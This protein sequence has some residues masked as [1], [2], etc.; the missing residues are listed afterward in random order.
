MKFKSIE[1]SAFRAYDKPEDASF[2]FTDSDG[3]ALNFV[4]LYAPNGFGKTSFYDAVEWG[5]T[6]EVSRLWRRDKSTEKSID[7]L[8]DINADKKR[9]DLLRNTNATGNTYV[10]YLTNKNSEPVKRDLAS[11]RTSKADTRSGLGTNLNFQ[12]VILSQEWISAFL[13]EDD[14][15]VRYKKFMKNPE[16]QMTDT[17]YQNLRVL[18]E[19]NDKRLKEL[20]G[21]IKTLESKITTTD[22]EDIL[23]AINELITRINSDYDSQNISLITL[24]TSQKEIKDLR[25]IITNTLIDNNDLDQL[26]ELLDS[27]DKARVGSEGLC[28]EK[29]YF[30]AIEN[31]E[32]KSK[33]QIEIEKNLKKFEKLNAL[34]NEREKL[35]SEKDKLLTEKKKLVNLINIFDKYQKIQNDINDKEQVKGT[36]KDQAST[37]RKNIENSNRE[38]LDAKNL[39]DS[40][41][42]RKTE[43]EK[44]SDSLPGLEADL[45]K[46]EEVIAT[47]ETS[48]SK[49]NEHILQGQERLAKIEEQIL[50][51]EQIKQEALQ[52]RY[53]LTSVSKDKIF[54]EIVKKL[55][56]NSDVSYELKKE[57]KLLDENIDQQEK[58]NQNIQE[59]ISEGLEIVNN[60]ETD[61]CPLCEYQYDSYKTLADRI[62]NNE[63]LSSALRILLQ[64]KNKLS[65]DVKT[66]NLAV[67]TLLEKL[68]AFYEEKLR[69]LKN[70]QEVEKAGIVENQ[71]IL[72]NFKKEL[73][74]ILK[75]QSDLLSKSNGRSINF[76]R[77]DLKESLRESIE[78]LEKANTRLKGAGKQL[79]NFEKNIKSIEGRIQLMISEIIKLEKDFDFITIKKWFEE[80]A[81][82][83]EIEKSLIEEELLKTGIILDKKLQSLQVLQQENDELAETLKSFNKITL[84]EK[85]GILKEE[86]QDL[87]KTIAAFDYFLKENLSIEYDLQKRENLKKLLVDKEKTAKESFD[88]IKKMIDDFHKLEKYSE[89]IFPFLLTENSKVILEAEKEELKFLKKSVSPLINEELKKTREYLET[90]IKDFFYVDL[91]NEIYEKIDPHPDF[92]S[93]KFTANF[94]VGNP[95]LDVFVEDKD[96]QNMLIPNLYF[97]TAQINILS[98][99]IFLASAMN[100]N[101][102]DCI[103]IDDPIQSM[104]SINVLS[105]IDLFRSIIVNHDKQ[106]ILSTH[107]QNFHNLLKKKIPTKIFKSKFMELESFGKLKE[108]IIP[109]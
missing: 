101:D 90:K 48:I 50:E 16:L 47:K 36:L 75:T 89:N 65:E 98:L 92:K 96:N 68:L 59:F 67:E 39:L 84:E 25:D 76:Y 94:D 22:E 23:K 53:S 70:T 27:I 5:I 11:R 34:K 19:I 83:N 30:E 62:T 74:N 12:R 26:A 87:A 4:S 9:I 41:I 100:S 66:I 46:A 61:S 109:T 15:E 63:A 56:E 20:K 91:I 71:K 99:S 6:N 95:S 43:L 37:L 107:D 73:T 31:S 28:S 52:G 18:K 13:K 32:K 38:Q 35:L 17:Y 3:E 97:S 82:N 79:A 106:I 54:I 45:K 78:N 1:I 69:I 104:D 7:R 81:P 58:L 72:Q 8:R 44:E 93:V 105:T 64:Q 49:V 40:L 77:K 60:G 55:L 42:K 86:K 88:K 29:Q 51:L 102:Y 2:N 103:F 24:S 108:D 33:D 14:G 80:N 57:L 21:N 85:V 10:K